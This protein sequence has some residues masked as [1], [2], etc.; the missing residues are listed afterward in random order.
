[1]SH[2]DLKFCCLF[3]LSKAYKTVVG[4]RKCEPDVMLA[5]ARNFA[6]ENFVER[7]QARLRA[8]LSDRCRENAN[9][10]CGKTI[11]INVLDVAFVS[12]SRRQL[13][14]ATID[15]QARVEG[16]DAQLADGVAQG[17]QLDGVGR[18]E[19]STSQWVGARWEAQL[20]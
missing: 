9:S 1:M 5:D 13:L 15:V 20:S 19:R 12:A 11:F 14:A 6:Y 16:A 18:V 7:F 10:G 3:S 8:R 4:F 17:E 2:Y